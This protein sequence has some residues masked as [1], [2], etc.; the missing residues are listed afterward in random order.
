MPREQHVVFLC[1]YAYAKESSLRGRKMITKITLNAFGF[2]CKYVGWKDS[3]VM[4]AIKRSAG[5][6]SGVNLKN[7]LPADDKEARDGS[8][9]ALKPKTDVTR[10]PK[11][12]I[13]GYS[14]FFFLK[15]LRLYGT[16]WRINKNNSHVWNICLSLPRI[17]Y[18]YYGAAYLFLPIQV[19]WYNSLAVTCQNVPVTSIFTD[20]T[21]ISWKDFDVGF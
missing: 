14:K 4:L 5:V 9:L 20:F 11:R 3:D 16:A 19:I 1:L 17:T 7:P 2:V 10:C 15:R 6:A 13:R 12:G 21:L 18:F 8:T